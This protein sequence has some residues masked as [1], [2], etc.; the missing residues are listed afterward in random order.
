MQ[1]DTTSPTWQGDMGRNWVRLRDGTDRQM[2]VV[3]DALAPALAAQPGQRVLDLGC[4]AGTT[5]LAIAQAVGPS[6]QATGLDISPDL[7]AEGRQRAAATPNAS[8]IEADA[9][10]HAFQPGQ[11]DALASRHGCMFFADPAAAFTNIRRS[12]RPGARIALS[13][14][15]P[16]EDNPWAT[17]PMQAVADTLGSAPADPPGA[18]GPFAWAD[19][20][21]FDTA[22][23][24]AGFR[25]IAAQAR[26][27]RFTIGVGD[28]PDPVDRAIAMM[29][30]IG[31]AARRVMMTGGDAATRVRPALRAALAPH[32]T[33]G[34]VR[35]PAR[36]WIVTA[37]A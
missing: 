15:G 4:G 28:D 8:F 12:L 19:R 37:T 27:L 14:F 18:P 29:L 21:V 5:T 1:P 32:V 33:D 7:I 35:L 2:A 10:N 3:W 9:A 24:A 26:D 36:I 11:F 17:V 6:G 30:G 22:L 16:L 31:M 13:A 20:R 34:W 23:A 25:D